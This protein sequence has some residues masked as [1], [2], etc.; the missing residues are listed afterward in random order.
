[1]RKNLTAAFVASVRA[2][3]KGQVDYWDEKLAGFGL[4]VS[5]GGRCTWGLLYRTREGR[6]RRYKIGTYPPMELAVARR[7][8]KDLLA[9]VQK[10]VDI[11]AVKQAARDGDSF[12]TIADRYMKEYVPVKN[13]KRTQSDKRQMLEA[14]LLPK[15]E[16]R[17][18]ASITRKE[19]IALVD[20]IGERAPIHANRV[21]AL[22]SSIFNF[23][24]DKEILTASPALRIPLPGKEKARERVLSADEVRR[25]WV[26]LDGEP[27]TIAA[28]FRLALLTAQRKGEI[29]GMRWDEL[30][31][32]G[33]WWTLP[34][35]RTKAGR[36]H[37]VP[38]VPVAVE[39][40]KA[41]QG[42]RH[43]PAFVFRGNRIGQP[44]RNLDNALKRVRQSSGVNFWLH[45]LR[46]TAA[47]EMGRLG[48]PQIV[49]GRILNQTDGSVTARH[50][51]L[52]EHDAE[53]REAL[54]KLEQWL[55][56]I[57]VEKPNPRLVAVA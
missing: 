48:V 57:V 32:E 21:A 1:M 54:M 30:D 4:R 13:R 43:D 26:A 38:L 34:G 31:L 55:M 51:A 25:V 10:G 28:I 6:S 52:Y 12:G 46:R 5:Q 14:D 53:K 44:V 45:D 35:E 50:Y 29:A 17:Q 42:G 7:Q 18:A 40:I 41:I 47:T 9:D 19:V 22:V 56:A 2:P 8:A 15:W 3:E 16:H 24:L 33:G 20:A 36:A 37:R 39:I 23:A 11:A 27:A 49:I